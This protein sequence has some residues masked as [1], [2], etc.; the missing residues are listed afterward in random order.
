MLNPIR[1]RSVVDTWRWDSAGLNP[2]LATAQGS[3]P[4]TILRV[5]AIPSARERREAAREAELAAEKARERER[6]KAREK[7]REAE[8][9]LWGIPK[10]AF[11]LGLPDLNF[12]SQASMLAGWGNGSGT[13]DF[14]PTPR[15][16]SAH[17]A[18]GRT[19]SVTS[20]GIGGGGESSRRD[21]TQRDR[22]RERERAE[23]EREAERQRKKEEEERAK[24]AEMDEP[25]DPEELA[26]LNAIINTRRSAAS[27]MALASGAVKFGEPSNARRGSQASAADTR[28]GLGGNGRTASRESVPSRPSMSARRSSNDSSVLGSPDKGSARI[29]FAPLPQ[30]FGPLPAHLAQVTPYPTSNPGDSATD[31]DASRDQAMQQ[32]TGAGLPRT[33][34]LNDY[35]DDESA[36]DDEGWTRRFS[37]GKGKW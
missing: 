9:K 2:G 17:G 24:D 22:D 19:H 3:P 35:A 31:L 29:R 27:A 20:G 10:K 13:T 11:Y 8:D 1:R 26:A 12:N 14:R 23:R 34:S 7:E 33:D 15:P 6:E 18:H 25:M 5:P 4:L 16:Q 32:L 36:S 21:S 30:P 37:S 28:P